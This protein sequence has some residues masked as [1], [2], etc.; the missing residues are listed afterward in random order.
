MYTWPLPHPGQAIEPRQ[1]IPGAQIAIKIK[2]CNRRYVLRD[3][4]PTSLQPHY[5]QHK[6]N[7]SISRRTQSVSHQHSSLRFRLYKYDN[8]NGK[9][10]LAHPAHWGHIM[11][12]IFSLLSG[13]WSLIPNLP[14][15]PSPFSLSLPQ[16][17][18]RSIFCR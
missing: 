15:A 18:R 4:C 9:S 2:V 1:F 11:V 7:Q 13:A 6:N 14:P 5:Q 17:Q 12:G 10:K 8:T 16:L 3:V